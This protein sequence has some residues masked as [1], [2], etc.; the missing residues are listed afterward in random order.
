MT[1]PA[2][3]HTHIA[4]AYELDA[5]L[6]LRSGDQTESIPFRVVEPVEAIATDG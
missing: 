4:I 5:R 1:N 3:H 6:H 2:L